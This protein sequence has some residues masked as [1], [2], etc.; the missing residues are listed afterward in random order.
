[1]ITQQQFKEMCRK[2][3]L[4]YSYSDDFRY[5]TAGSRS[6]Q[7]IMEAAEE[8]GHDLAARIWN[9]VVDEKLIEEI[10][11]DWYWDV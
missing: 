10:R 9:E 6:Y 7:K 3:D 5:F 8:L 11:K 1:M 2:H 4:T